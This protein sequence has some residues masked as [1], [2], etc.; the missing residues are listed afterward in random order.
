MP[1]DRHY[2]IFPQHLN[3]DLSTQAYLKQIQPGCESTALP[4][5]RRLF[6]KTLLRPWLLS[7]VDK[8]MLLRDWTGSPV[9]RGQ[10][11]EKG[12]TEGRLPQWLLL[13]SPTKNLTIQTKESF[14]EQG[15]PVISNYPTLDGWTL[16]HAKINRLK[17]KCIPYCSEIM[18]AK[19]PRF[20]PPGEYTLQNEIWQPSRSL[21]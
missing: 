13:F 4:S 16:E 15:C 9:W 14:R 11:G 1:C 19:T 21:S 8:W 12:T 6:Q 20:H 2:F 5:A 7:T 3:Q 10:R 18:W 17:I